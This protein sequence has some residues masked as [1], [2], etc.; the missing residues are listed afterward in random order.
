MSVPAAVPVP[1]NERCAGGEGASLPVGNFG[2]ISLFDGVSS[3]VPSVRS[4][5]KSLR[6]LS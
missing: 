4:S 1:H 3:I 5:S 6:L 2:I